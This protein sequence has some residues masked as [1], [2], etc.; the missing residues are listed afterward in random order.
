[1]RAYERFLKYV[2]INTRSDDM[3]GRTPSSEGQFDLARLLVEEM[4]QI[5]IADAYVDDKCYVY[6]SIPATPGYEEVPCVMFCAHLDTAAFN[7]ENVRPQLIE[8][9]NGEDI[10]LGKSGKVLSPKKFPDLKEITGQTLIVTDGTTLLG[11]DDKA[12]IAEIM[13]MAETVIREKLPHGRLAISFPPDEEICAGAKDLDLEKLGADVGYTVDGGKV[14]MVQYENFNA[15]LVQISIQGFG[16]HPGSAKDVMVNA[17]LVANELNNMLPY[18]DL[19][20]NTTGYEGFFHVTK[21]NGTPDECTMEYIIRDHDRALFE[22][23]K[24]CIMHIAELLNDRYGKDTVKITITDEY[25]NMADVIKEHYELIEYAVQAVRMAGE[26]EIMKPIRGGTD[27][28]QLSFRGLPCPDIGTG[29]YGHHGP[30]EHITV[31]ALDK[32]TEILLNVVR[33]FAE[34]K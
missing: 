21:W 16:V 6:G 13:T 2:V 20:R 18:G 26:K 9:Y 27:G 24:K 14:G 4:H 5:G 34:H 33:L 29:V 19:P 8:N 23:R 22:G 31:E 15:A 28:C 1:M 32:V 12:G 25:F 10:P 17:L 7:A 11:A 3:T 30:F